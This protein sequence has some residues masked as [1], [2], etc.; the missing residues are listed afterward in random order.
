MDMLTVLVCLFLVSLSVAP[1]NVIGSVIIFWSVL[2]MLIL[3][4]VAIYSCIFEREAGGG[5]LSS[6]HELFECRDEDGRVC[7]SCRNYM[8]NDNR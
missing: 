8:E 1:T 6:D 5:Y 7:D 2:A 3:V 4:F